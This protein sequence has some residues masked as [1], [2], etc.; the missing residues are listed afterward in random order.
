MEMGI[1]IIIVEI[2][3]EIKN[4]WNKGVKI[5][6]VVSRIINRAKRKRK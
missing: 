4:I 1:E 2:F 3:K 6:E 5:K